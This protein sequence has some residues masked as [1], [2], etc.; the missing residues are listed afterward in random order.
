MEH[1]PTF[2]PW[3]PGLESEIPSR[4]MPLVT[5]YRPENGE[6]SY[7]QAVELRDTFG[8]PLEALATF[9]PERL[10]IHRLLV[11]VTADFTLKDG[12]AYEEL[13]ISLRGMVD[14][15]FTRYVRQK[16]AELDA[17]YEGVR[18]EAALII[19]AELTDK[20][21]IPK[22]NSTEEK[23]R[24]FLG[25]FFSKNKEEPPRES[26][27]DR[28]LN[29]L[30]DWCDKHSI[31]D[32]LLRE[33]CLKALCRVVGS[34]IGQRGRIVADNALIRDVCVRLVLNHYGAIEINRVLDP[35]IDEAARREQY[36]KLPSQKEP[37]IFNVKGASASGKSTIRGEQRRMAERLGVPWED[38]ALISP[39][40]W[41]KYLMEYESLGDDYKYGAMLTGRELEI[42]DRK[43]DEYMAAKA[44]DRG[45]SHLLI[46]R[47]RFDS[48]S[49]DPVDEA[50]SR[51][52][53]RFG[54]TIYL[55]FMVTPPAA[56]VERA[57]LRGLST[58]RYKAVDDLLYHNIE[59]Y[60][61][62][63]N[64]FF[65]WV[66]SKEKGVHFE[67]LDNSVPKGQKPKTIA[68]GWNEEMVVYDIE[69][70]LDIA[71]FQFVDI[72][73]R[74]PDEI[75]DG[76]A[77]G[78]DATFLE[79]CVERL[80]MVRFIEPISGE[81]YAY[82]QDGMICLVAGKKHVEQKQAIKKA[83]AESGLKLVEGEG[84]GVQAFDADKE[85]VCSVGSW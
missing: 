78:G 32:D 56:L 2:T 53:T 45:I 40:Y 69:A 1:E 76:Q 8:L 30:R 82:T 42:I 37:V 85:R 49:T 47:F 25:L 83:L 75:F 16:L 10:V 77:R 12:P 29:A 21:S 6:V 48:F 61:G 4:L 74:S 36:R 19:E 80:S 26:D 67:F 62:M 27:E 7:E 17:H 59:A 58:G 44:N 34:H 70:L 55:F 39:D 20:L 33:S 22:S 23:R 5:L 43:L 13:G 64:L 71:R 81:C 72:E 38:F 84:G 18:R 60:T 24:G 50:S 14:Q 79:S 73:A 63:P 28:Q 65:S 66:Q 35:M 31:E 51:L 52:L 9:T 41:R 46:D 11:R 54:H 57:W 3:N 15:L 68:L